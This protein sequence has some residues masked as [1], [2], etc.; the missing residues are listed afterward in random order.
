[1]NES[2][3]KPGDVV[4]LKSD[5]EHKMKMTVK[6]VSDDKAIL[7]YFDPVKFDIKTLDASSQNGLSVVLLKKIG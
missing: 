7:M 3:F 5:T 6:S 1:M 2:Q 4:V